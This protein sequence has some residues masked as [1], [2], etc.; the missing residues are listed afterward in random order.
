MLTTSAILIGLLA[1][2]IVGLSKAALPGGAMLATP[3][4]ATV[5]EGRLIPGAMLPV[6]MVADIFAVSWYAKFAR[7]DLI[8]PLSTWVS[9]GFALGISFFIGVGTATRSLE[10]T[11]GTIVLTMV[12][13]Q[14]WRASRST[15]PVPSGAAA[16]GFGIA[17]GFSTFV[18]NSA[19][20][21]MNSYLAGLQVSKEELVGTSAWFFFAVN[22]TKVPFYL[23]LGQWSDGGRFFTWE[24]LTYDLVLVPGVI[25]GVFG[26]RKL[27]G[28]LPQKRFLQ[29]VLVF[30][31]AGGLKLL[32]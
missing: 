25:A 7:W 10:I 26:G 18:S 6:L 11:I 32:F 24:S 20:P 30:S 3:L 29:I 1:A 8:R 27:F 23:A 12:A 17:G 28:H 5:V 21:V 4:I 9:V 14:I 19:G 13:V 22:V 2:F 15:P 31:A 16:A